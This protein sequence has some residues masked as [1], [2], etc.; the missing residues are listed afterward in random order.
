MKSLMELESYPQFDWYQGTVAEDCDRRL[1]DVFSVCG[2]EPPVVD[3]GMHGYTRSWHIRRDGSNWATIM[4]GHGLRDHFYA[5]GSAARDV[6]RVV[7]DNFAH[8]VSRAD[9]AM[10]FVQG[11]S[12]FGTTRE[13]LR[14]LLRGKVTLTD[15]VE[16]APTGQ[17]SATFYAGSRK[18]EVRV[19]LYEKGKEDA[20]YDPDTARLEV[21]VRPGTKAR[22]VYA[23]SL[24]PIGFFGMARWTRATL[25]AVAGLDVTPAP[26]RSDRVS[27][28]DGALSALVHQYGPRL[29]E[30]MEKHEGDIEAFALDLLARIYNRGEPDATSVL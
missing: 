10:D 28:L 11:P 26:P 2:D 7:R 1:M 18:S 20:S 25:E 9:V 13:S 23:S 4:E 14:E 19:R 6:S 5:S 16:V 22:K 27:D 15:Y 30:L 29:L 12:F 8:S 3:R 21:Q 24:E 17:E